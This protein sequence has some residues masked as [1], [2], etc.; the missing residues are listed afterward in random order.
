MIKRIKLIKPINN[1]FKMYKTMPNNINPIPVFVNWNSLTLDLEKNPPGKSY[2]NLNINYHLAISSFEGKQFT[3]N[4][5]KMSLPLLLTSNEPVLGGFG[6]PITSAEGYLF[7]INF[8]TLSN[9][10]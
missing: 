1:S 6:F 10:G 3:L 5:E 7:F 9:S 4:F 8:D 2:L